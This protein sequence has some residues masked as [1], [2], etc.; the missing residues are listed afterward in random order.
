MESGQLTPE[1][2]KFLQGESSGDARKDAEIEQQLGQLLDQIIQRLMEE[3]FLNIGEAPQMPAGYDSVFGPAGQARSAARQVQFSLT[4]K[5]ADFL[6]FKTLKQLLGSVGKSSAGAHDTPHFATGTEAEVASK[7]YE[8]GD[9]LNLDVPATLARA[10]A[11]EGIKVP[12][13]LEYGD[14]M[15]HQSEYRSSA[16]TVLMLDCSHSMILYGEDRFTPAKKV[17]LALTHLIRTQFAGDSI[18]C[19]LFHDSAEEI[20]L[21]AL[22]QVQV[23]PYHTNTAEG[24]KLARRILAGQKKDMRQIIMITDGKPSAM[25]MPDGRVYVNSMGLDPTHPRGDLPRGVQLPPRRHHDQHLHAGAGAV[26]GG[27]REAGVGDLPREGLLHL[28]DDTGTVHSDGL[29]EAEDAQGVVSGYTVKGKRVRRAL[30]R[31][32]HGPTRSP[33]TAS[34]LLRHHPLHQIP[35]SSS[36]PP[37]TSPLINASLSIS[38]TEGYRLLNSASVVG[39]VTRAIEIRLGLTLSAAWSVS[40]RKLPTN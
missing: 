35:G 8:F 17:A 10:I 16:A 22:S 14:L 39:W 1:M 18:R 25:T 36:A 33:F 31:S 13:D 30:D 4:E 40:R 3:G 34:P 6:G 9:T 29:H 37:S 26:A 27:L 38:T 2:M 21:A 19:V 7:Q 28:D 20:P 5:G 23:G 11:R 15:V 12:I 32:P 24:L